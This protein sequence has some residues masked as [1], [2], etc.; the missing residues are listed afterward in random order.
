MDLSSNLLSYDKSDDKSDNKSDDTIN[1]T[2]NWKSD[3]TINPR[4]DKSTKTDIESI[5]ELSLTVEIGQT[6]KIMELSKNR[7]SLNNIKKFSQMCFISTN[8][9]KVLDG[10][11][12]AEQNKNVFG[13][14]LVT[15]IQYFIPVFDAVK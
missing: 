6:L 3:D 12:I 9:I 2:I 5:S 11:Y 8:I 4:Y 7:F 15:Y 1:L 10:P 14:Y 13:V